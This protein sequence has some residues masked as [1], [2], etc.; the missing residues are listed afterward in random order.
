M[1]T[2][3]ELQTSGGQ[4]SSLTFSFADIKQAKNKYHTILAYAAVSEVDRHAAAILNDKGV[5]LYH[6][7]YDHAAQEQGGADE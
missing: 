4:T 6:E 7:S 2:V 3:I 5:S 1:Y